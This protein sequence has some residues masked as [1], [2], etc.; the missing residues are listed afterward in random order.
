M[1]L[2]V[3][4]IIGLMAPWLSRADL[5]THDPAQLRWSAVQSKLAR[6][7]GWLA[8]GH[9]RANFNGWVS[10]ADDDAFFFAS[11]GKHDPEAELLATLDALYRRGRGDDHP[12]C[13]FPARAHWLANRLGIEPPAPA[14]P[15]FREW[16][17]KLE[18]QAVSLIFP[19]AYLNSPSSMFGHTFLRLEPRDMTPDQALLAA[20]VNYAADADDDNE[21]FYALRGLF[22]GYPGR[23][24]VLPY[25]EK[26]KEYSDF[27]NRDI[28]EYRLAL[29]PDEVEQLVR[30]VWELL[31]IRFD[32]FFIGEN[33]SYRLLGMLDVARPGLG[34]R[35][36]FPT[37]A[38]P[39]DTVRAI[40][41]AG[42]MR[43]SRYRPSA[44]TVLAE[45]VNQLGGVQKTLA[46]Q[47]ADHP[48]PD[49]RLESLPPKN[50][51]GVL[52]AAYEFTR[53][54]ALD[55]K[56]PREASAATSYRLLKE[57]SRIDAPSPLTAPDT[58]AVRDD[59]GHRPK[60]M[61]AGFGV[62]DDQ[63]F[64]E[65]TARS[66]YHGLTDPWP[67]YQAGA[68]IRFLD[69]ALRYYE[70]DHL[71]FERLDVLDIRSYSPRDDFFTPLSWGVGLGARRALLRD[72][73]PLLGYFE[74]EVGHTYA[75]AGS[76]IYATL[77]TTLETGTA[78]D[79]GVQLGLGPRL[80]WLY[81]G[82][83][84]QGLVSFDA[85]C[86][87]IHDAWCGG[88][89]GLEHTLNLGANLGL[90]VRLSRELGQNREVD[91]IGIGLHR[92]F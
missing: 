38:F 19:A 28:W 80:G 68:Q 56:R 14:C 27:E 57:R 39:A 17:D 90:R 71:K 2:A 86:H 47:L 67:G 24:T 85:Q 20:T 16:R 22:G 58:P 35:H 82:L 36:R 21:V 51:A 63:A 60:A 79:A 83:G 7:E 89:L 26:V 53:Y 78:L 44:A 33:C 11:D 40:S 65:W 25:Y 73:R 77:G 66:A 62:W 70:D 50:R 6:E 8:L 55:E 42:L 34:L 37:R 91:E 12:A 9:Y 48:P 30:H 15:A 23:V 75:L 76:L 45:H 43:D 4:L 72:G 92:Y 29:D 54:R 13:R 18:A 87:V 64:G 41:E 74:G 32:Y 3:W 31:P 49:P 52:E 5:R 84:G 88:R 1:R 59:Q 61:S 81:R 46:R 10:D 69:G